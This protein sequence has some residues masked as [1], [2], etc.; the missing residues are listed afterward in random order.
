MN[1]LF[2]K[3]NSLSARD[4]VKLDKA[5]GWSLNAAEL[6]QAQAYFREIKREPARGELL[7]EPLF[8]VAC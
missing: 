7:D 2:S 6:K 5:Y 4:L 1:D 8:A 3:F